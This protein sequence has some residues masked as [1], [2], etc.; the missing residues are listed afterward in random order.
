MD[1]GFRGDY[2]I[3]HP[4][5]GFRSEYIITSCALVPDWRLIGIAAGVVVVVLALV[6]IGAAW[7][8]EKGRPW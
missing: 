5:E 1:D 4:S 7:L 2:I 8:A 3:T 6:G